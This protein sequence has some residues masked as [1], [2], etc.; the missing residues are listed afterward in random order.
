MILILVIPAKREREFI[1]SKTG[2][3][4]GNAAANRECV[5]L[6]LGRLREPI[7]SRDSGLGNSRLALVKARRMKG[8]LVERTRHGE[9]VPV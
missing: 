9:T 8:F 1:P 6:T 7:E 5:L 2:I 4:F 3:P